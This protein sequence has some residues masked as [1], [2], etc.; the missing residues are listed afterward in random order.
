M[1]LV[2]FGPLLFCMRHPK[3][4]GLKKP[5]KIFLLVFRQMVTGHDFLRICD[6]AL[7]IIHFIEQLRAWPTKE[8]FENLGPVPP[9]KQNGVY[10]GRAKNNRR[11]LS[12]RCDQDTTTWD[13]VTNPHGVAKVTETGYGPTANSIPWVLSQRV[14]SSLFFI[15]YI[16]VFRPDDYVKTV[17]P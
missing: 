11:S 3:F 17:A 15:K 5:F 16:Q 9:V 8:I 1:D 10:S 12:Q 6:C 2:H 7:Y 14:G 4:L 13:R